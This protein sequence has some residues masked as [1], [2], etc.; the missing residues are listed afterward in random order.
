MS[1][2]PINPNEEAAPD[3]RIDS[4]RQNRAPD[5]IA[6]AGSMAGESRAADSFDGPD[7]E[8]WP[9]PF[10]DS[11]RTQPVNSDEVYTQ[12]ES[13]AL[14]RPRNEGS[15]GNPTGDAHF[16]EMAPTSTS[17]ATAAQEAE[18]DDENDED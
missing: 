8:Q 18:E 1:E 7:E 6:D 14:D 4:Q 12:E 17:G 5:S 16:F 11:D 13:G 10:V 2:E 3:P 9:P 15:E